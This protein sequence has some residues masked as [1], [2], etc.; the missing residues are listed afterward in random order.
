MD[1][2][3]SLRRSNIDQEYDYRGWANKMPSLKFNP[4]WGVT[5]MPPFGGA[6]VR[7]RVEKNNKSVSVY[8]DAFD[9]LASVGSPYWEIYPYEDDVERF[10]FGEEDKM[11]DCI[12]EVLG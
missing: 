2:E 6:I 9:E 7:F 5:I 1:L 4:T 8:F 10:L 12:K 11:L 3:R